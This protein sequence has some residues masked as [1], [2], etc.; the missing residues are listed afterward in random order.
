MP[1]DDVPT[2]PVVDG[3]V[4]SSPQAAQVRTTESVSANEPPQFA[5]ARPSTTFEGIVRQRFR[6]A[7][8]W[9]D[10]FDWKFEKY[11]TPWII[12]ATWICCVAM[13]FIWSALIILL[14]LWSWAPEIVSSDAP[15][16]PNASYEVRESSFPTAPDWLTSRVTATIAGISALCFV[17]I[18]LLWIRVVLETAIVLFNIA[19][20][21]LS[22]D[23]KLE[24][25][26]SAAPRQ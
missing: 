12:R 8:S 1:P 2:F 6:P 15:S 3:P 24:R 23:R 5:P 19:T 26:G 10:I 13:G 9:F 4:A 18:L 7:T 22:I 21:L 14:T 17:L 11:L 20:T 25:P 16:R